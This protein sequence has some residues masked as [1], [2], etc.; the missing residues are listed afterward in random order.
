ME[1]EKEIEALRK[2]QM[3]LLDPCFIKYKK[4]YQGKANKKTVIIGF[5]K[6]D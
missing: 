4:Q 1:K 6:G 3:G 5:I 2:I